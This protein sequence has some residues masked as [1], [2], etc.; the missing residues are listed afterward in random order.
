MQIQPNKP[1]TTPALRFDPARTA[2]ESLKAHLPAAGEAAVTPETGPSDS[3]AARIKEARD[4]FRARR[5]GRIANLRKNY[6]ANHPNLAEEAVRAARD[7]YRAKLEVRRQNTQGT[8]GSK[9]DR[10][11]ISSTT[12]KLGPEI[13]KRLESA[14]PARTARL[15]ELRALYVEGKLNTPEL[16]ERAARRMLEGS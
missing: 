4:E 2:R 9:G 12:A 6:T 16:I 10:I 8:D 15:D 11:D 7:E 13:A 3:D 14:D 5:Q 1:D